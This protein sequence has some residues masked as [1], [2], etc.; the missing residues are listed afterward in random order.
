MAVCIYSHKLDAYYDNELSHEE[1]RKL[2]QHIRG[3]PYCSG[4]LEQ[5]QRLSGLISSVSIPDIPDDMAKRLHQSLDSLREKALLR[6][7]SMLSSVALVLLVVSSI[8]VLR[9]AV[10]GQVATASDPEWEKTAVTLQFDPPATETPELQFAQ[11][12]IADL[13]KE[14]GNE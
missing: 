11:W 6:M 14:N 8:L 3:C 5:R 2:E 13:S 4:D 7:A 10:K 1:H 12:L 9:I